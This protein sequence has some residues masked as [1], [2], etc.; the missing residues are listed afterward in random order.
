MYNESI[1]SIIHIFADIQPFKE[2][3]GTFSNETGILTSPSYPNPYPNNAEC[4]YLISQPNGTCVNLTVEAFDVEGIAGCSTDFLEI[5][6]GMD[7]DSFLLGKFCGS[8][9]GSDMPTSIQSTQQNLRISF[10]S[11]YFVNGEGFAMKY[12]ASNCAGGKACFK[13]KFVSEK[14]F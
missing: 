9:I 4:D 7:T 2:C 14:S 12:E 10:R 5:R 6:E 3:G 11:N 13:C 8:T 1:C